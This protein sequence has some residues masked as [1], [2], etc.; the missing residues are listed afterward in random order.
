MVS[1]ENEI[2]LYYV[3]LMPGSN[4]RRMCSLN[5]VSNSVEMDLGC[6]VSWFTFSGKWVVY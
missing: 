2:V 4:I 1:V 5:Y 6:S 3:L